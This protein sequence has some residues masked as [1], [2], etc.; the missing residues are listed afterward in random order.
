MVILC[1]ICDSIK[2]DYMRITRMRII[3]LRISENVKYVWE[4]YIDTWESY[5]RELYIYIWEFYVRGLD[6]WELDVW[7]LYIWENYIYEDYMR[8]R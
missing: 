8:I 4:V 2:Y 5:V 1:S 7:Y 3:C 6:I